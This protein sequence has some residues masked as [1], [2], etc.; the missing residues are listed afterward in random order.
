MPGC[1]GLRSRIAHYPV[2][3]DVARQVLGNLD[4]PAALA[5]DPD[6]GKVRL[7]VRQV[8]RAQ[9]LNLGIPAH[10]ISIAPHCTYSDHEH[11][12]SYRRQ[13]QRPLS[14]QWSGIGLN[15]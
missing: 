3:D 13:Q 12:F 7:D 4:I 1:L 9:C 6:P 11:F 15:H 10:Q 14:V 5:P 8:I 2:G